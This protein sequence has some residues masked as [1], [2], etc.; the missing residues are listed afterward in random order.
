MNEFDILKNGLKSALVDGVGDGIK[1]NPWKI[2]AHYLKL[3]TTTH[4][5]FRDLLRFHQEIQYNFNSG[6]TNLFTVQRSL[7]YGSIA[8]FAKDNKIFNEA[9]SNIAT[10]TKGCFAFTENS[11]GVYSGLKLNTTLVYDPTTDNFILDSNNDSKIW[12]SCA[13]EKDLKYIL[14]FA[15]YEQDQNKLYI[16]ILIDYGA[17]S[18]GVQ[19]KPYAI[20][21]NTF[22]ENNFGEIIFSQRRIEKKDILDKYYQWN[23]SDKK[24]IFEGTAKDLKLKILERLFVGRIML[25]GSCI[26]GAIKMYES[27]ELNIKLRNYDQGSYV[28]KLLSDS[29]DK[30]CR[31]NKY[32]YNL[33]DDLD[34]GII[35]LDK[36]NFAKI[37]I[38]DICIELFTELAKMLGGKAISRENL[39][40]DIGAI[41]GARVAEGDSFMLGLFLFNSIKFTPQKLFTKNLSNNIKILF[42]HL[43]ILIKMIF[44]KILSYSDKMIINYL[45]N[46]I[47]EYYKN[48]Q[49]LV[50]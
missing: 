31:M 19:I 34:Q 42:Y 45:Q 32:L 41:Y 49:Y 2:V 21:K 8:A 28:K 43:K 16:P 11:L 39:L 4:T 26:V 38:P 7:V 3:S 14:T 40:G 35:N 5:K 23:E 13:G 50:L 1:D 47:F 15:T 24:F 48:I 46:D 9:K 37:I 22:V 44:Y 27:A 29:A 17:N 20:D 18:D 12:I 30:I 25:S 36:I 33:T 10:G 6:I